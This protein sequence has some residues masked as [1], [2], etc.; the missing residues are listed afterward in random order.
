MTF[1]SE[2]KEPTPSMIS[3]SGGF[4]IPLFFIFGFYIFDKPIVRLVCIGLFALWVLLVLISAAKQ[5]DWN[6][7]VFPCIQGIAWMLIHPIFKK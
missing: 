2:R 6:L 1:E 7:L 4:A 3:G 5:S